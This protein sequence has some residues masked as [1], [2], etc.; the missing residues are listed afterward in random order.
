M[1]LK[2][3]VFFICMNLV[4][5]HCIMRF[6][7]EINLGRIYVFSF[8]SMFYTVDPKKKEKPRKKAPLNRGKHSLDK[9]FA[10]WYFSN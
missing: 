4:N 6:K 10:S 9:I 2:D 5:K 8:I 1:A 3:T 7:L